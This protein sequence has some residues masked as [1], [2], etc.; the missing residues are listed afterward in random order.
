MEETND[1]YG[2]IFSKIYHAIRDLIYWIEND[3]YLEY[4]M[5]N[6]ERHITH[7]YISNL[8]LCRRKGIFSPFR[9][10]FTDKDDEEK[11]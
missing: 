6:K 3:S 4:L 5:P 9:E 7:T 10:K 11:I 2:R 1:K 8:L